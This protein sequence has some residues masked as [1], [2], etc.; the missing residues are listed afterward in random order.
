MNFD[1]VDVTGGTLNINSGVTTSLVF[2]GTG[3]TV[4]WSDGF[5][6][7][8]Q[9]WLVFDNVSAPVIGGV[10]TILFS[11]DNLGNDLT[12]VRAGSSFNWEVQGNDIYLNYVVPEPSTYALLVLSAAGL[13]AHVVRRRRNY[14]C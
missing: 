9:S 2:N 7:S 10:P 12:S 6:G 8:N 5:W 4:L 1:G 11:Q 14:R 13:A 3:S